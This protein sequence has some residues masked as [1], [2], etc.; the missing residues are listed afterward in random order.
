MP[1]NDNDVVESCD[2]DLLLLNGKG[3]CDLNLLLLNRKGY[4]YRLNKS[5]MRNDGS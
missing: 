5:S 2:L 1:F 4:V 3:S